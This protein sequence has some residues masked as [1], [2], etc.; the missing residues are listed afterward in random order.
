MKFFCNTEKFDDLEEFSI[1]SQYKF[2]IIANSTL[3]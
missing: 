2:A 3:V 1:F